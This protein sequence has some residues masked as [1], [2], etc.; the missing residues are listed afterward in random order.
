M[1]GISRSAT[2][3]IAYLMKYMNMP[4]TQAFTSISAKRR[5][6]SYNLCRSILILGL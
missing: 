3:V 2:L 5:K 6:V 1:A 4:M